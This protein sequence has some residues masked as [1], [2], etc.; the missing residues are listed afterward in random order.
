MKYN[1]VHEIIENRSRFIAYVI[2]DFKE[3]DSVKEIYNELKK[4]H[5]KASHVCWAYSTVIDGIEMK[6]Y[7]DDG[8]PK[9]TAGIPIL[10][11]IEMKKKQDILILVVR[12]FG[13]SRLGASKLLRTYRR[14]TNEAIEL[15]GK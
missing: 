2:T 9:G 13:G 7:S 11:T 3:I 14:S 4:E 1:L 6:K 8:E 12:Y 15:L 10:S 5:K